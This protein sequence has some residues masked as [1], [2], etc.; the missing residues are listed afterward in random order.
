[1]NALRCRRDGNERKKLERMPMG[2]AASPEIRLIEL[3][4]R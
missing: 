1:M 4:P 2:L 3:D